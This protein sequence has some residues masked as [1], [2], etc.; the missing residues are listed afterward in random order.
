MDLVPHLRELPGALGCTSET[1]SV[2]RRLTEFDSGASEDAVWVDDSTAAYAKVR[3]ALF[4]LLD[5]I[6]DEQSLLIV[7]EDVQWIDR[8]SAKLLSAMISWARSKKALFL[9]NERASSGD[10]TSQFS[11]LDL[12]TIPLSPLEPSL[13]MKLVNAIVDEESKRV[14]P[15]VIKWLLSVGE[16]NP[17][18]LQ[19]LVKQ[20]L[21]T[22]KQHE[23]PPSLSAVIDDRLSR[24]SKEALRVLQTC[25]VLGMNA[26]I[27]RVERALDFKP[28]ELL[29]AAEELCSA[30]ML[31]EET[32]PASDIS[33]KLNARHDLLSTAALA[34][35]A[36][37]PLGFLHR[38]AGTVLEQETLGKP[39]STSLLWACAFHWRNAGDRERAFTAARTC[40]E[41]ILEVGLPVDSALAFES[42]LEYCG[43]EEQRLL[44][45]PRL[46]I[47]LQMQGRW[48]DSK[49]VLR[50]CR[51]IRAKITPSANT[52]DDEEL[53]LLDATWRVTMDSFSVLTDVQACVDSA[54]A[55]E[56]HRVASG[57]LGLK[58]AN[59]LSEMAIMRGLHEKIE[60]VLDH[61]TIRPS[62]RFE[63]DMIFQSACGDIEKA[64]QATKQFLA[65]V[66][67]EQDPLTFSRALVNAGVA[68]RLAGRKDEAETLFL[69]A[70]EHAVSHGLPAR[71]NFAAYS[72]VRLYLAAGDVQRA[73]SAMERAESIAQSS[74]DVHDAA[75]RLYLDARLALDA[76][77]IAAASSRYEILRTQTTPNQS[78]NRVSAVL[79]LGI[80]I[81]IM[82][83]ASTDTLRPLVSELEAAHLINRG[84]GWQDFETHALYLGLV[85]C[86]AA[87]R[88]QRLLAEYATVYRRE[89]WP[90][91]RNLTDLLEAMD[92]GSERVPSDSS[93]LKHKYEPSLTV[94]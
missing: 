11:H 21:E 22:G 37:K 81:G 23:F 56:M 77:D 78:V 93:P 65:A 67:A 55:S 46:A 75:D 72:L 35:L 85:A 66:R 94:R 16:G 25:A 41:H 15:D 63:V 79:A 26:T 83:G 31:Q 30:G 52:H 6:A 43:T 39:V 10:F 58:L 64:S 5:A 89:K 87:E 20:W 68:H 54:S 19:E 47:A 45:L 84:G 32:E 1:L 73:Q 7:L 70:L 57:L 74:D 12:P 2:L 33:D 61:P 18:F 71:A 44:V 69:E 29:S 60:P 3:H 92:V 51:Q 48:D 86:G 90:L 49:E 50:R 59:N 38:R 34:R 13:A 62:T 40:A 14:D 4:D 80:R 8:S 27:E 28:H 91:P 82:R 36:K 53:A 24:L 76:G 42:A 9:L 88:G 17:F